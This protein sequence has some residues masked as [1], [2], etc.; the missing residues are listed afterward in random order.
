MSQAI[1]CAAANVT[2]IS[3]FVG[4]IL[5][6]Y[7]R[8][9][10]REYGAWEDPGVVFVKEVF[11]YYKSNNC[12][13]IIMGASFRNIDEILQLAGCDKLTIS[14][15]LMSE[16]EKSNKGIS[17]PLDQKNINDSKEITLNE[18]E[19]RYKLNENAMATEKLAE[20][21]RTF[22]KDQEKLESILKS[23]K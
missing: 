4:R 17:N 6:W 21:I 14:P 5:D 16:L 3:P 18:S 9:S 11:N 19:F 20:G 2:L 7:K 8:E 12:K 13:T 23:Y 10:G 15:A 1:A 22:C